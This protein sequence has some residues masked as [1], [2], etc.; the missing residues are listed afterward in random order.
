MNPYEPPDD[1]ETQ[2]KVYELTPKGMF[3]ALMLRA[4]TSEPV[5]M[6]MSDYAEEQWLI[7]EAM[8]IRQLREQDPEAPF[9]ALVFDGSG[10]EIVGVAGV[11]DV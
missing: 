11:D 3:I 9:A 2:E 6:S 7:F 10:G 8:I 5:S 4:M 1:D